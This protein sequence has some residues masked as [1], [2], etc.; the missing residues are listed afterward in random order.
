MKTS[1]W[2]IR[3]SAVRAA[4]R[5]RPISSSVEPHARRVNRT[6]LDLDL[7]FDF[8]LDLDVDLSPFDDGLRRGA[9]TPLD[10][11]V[12]RL[13]TKTGKILPNSAYPHG[14]TSGAQVATTEVVQPLLHKLVALAALSFC[15]GGLGCAKAAKPAAAP[16][17]DYDWSTYNG[18]KEAPT[19]DTKK[20]AADKSD[21]SSTDS[22][23]AKSSKPETVAAAPEASSASDDPKPGKP[24]VSSSGAH[25]ASKAKIKGESVSSVGADA[26]AGASKKALKSKVV[27]SNVITGPDYEMVQIVLKDASVQIV[28]P[29][30]TPDSSGPKLRSPKVRNDSLT[31]TDS[32]F[33]DA[34]ADVLVLVQ[35][36]KAAKSKK[37]LAALMKK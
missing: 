2:E 15:L 8:D 33:Y 3:T 9:S 32:A 29:A 22:K 13:A 7:D 23:P 6:D 30:T 20:P 35:S 1:G 10:Q 25:K 27:S 26:V 4:S 14:A 31:S 28:R 19:A 21:S 5:V 36:S 16:E 34:D 17:P 18:G 24:D 12:P 11:K 37:A